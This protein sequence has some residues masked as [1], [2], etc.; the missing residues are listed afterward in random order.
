[1]TVVCVTICTASVRL[2]T[3]NELLQKQRFDHQHYQRPQ[4][5]LS[6][7][8]LS[9]EAILFPIHKYLANIINP[10]DSFLCFGTF[11]LY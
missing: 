3:N 5:I 11:F 4:F 2:S 9:F 10:F 7:F 8:P 6:E 1:M